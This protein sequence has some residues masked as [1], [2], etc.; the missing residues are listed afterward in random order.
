MN[1]VLKQVGRDY[2]K[3]LA[4]R[5]PGFAGAYRT[6]MQFMVRRHRSFGIAASIILTLHVAVVLLSGFTSLTGMAAGA[7]LIVTAG[8]GLYG[9][10]VV[11]IPRGRWIHAH[12]TGAFLLL[13]AAVVHFFSKAYVFL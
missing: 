3:R 4:V 7:L 1:F 2:V 8:L 6:F 12:R 9:F 13:V 5:N 10:H 11:K